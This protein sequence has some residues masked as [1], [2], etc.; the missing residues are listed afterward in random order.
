MNHLQPK[1]LTVS[2]WL[3]LCAPIVAIAAG[4]ASGSSNASVASTGRSAGAVS[5]SASAAATSP[6]PTESAS[7]ATEPS[8]SQ[9]PDT[10]TTAGDVPDNAVFLT[11]HDSTVKFSIQY[12]EGWQVTR[13]PNGVSIHDKDS[14]EVIL[15]VAGQTDAAAYISAT[16]LPGLHAQ[17]GFK[18]IKQDTVKVGAHYVNHLAY[19]I[20][21]PADPVTGKQVPSSADRYYMPGTNGLA[22]VSL[23]TPKGVDNVDAFRRMIESFQWA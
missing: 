10:G 13:D 2:R 17:A 20:L 8:M 21:S 19:E 7:V 4:C 14:S 6:G 12:V 18:L 3:I 16:D 9:G 22:V 23:S 5:S 1:H 15:V 11:Y